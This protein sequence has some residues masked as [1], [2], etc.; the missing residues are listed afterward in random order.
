MR[1]DVRLYWTTK[2]QN[3][4][5]NGIKNCFPSHVVLFTIRDKLGYND[6]KRNEYFMP[7]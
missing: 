4:V 6:K 1:C 3:T 7:L 5:D 2:Y